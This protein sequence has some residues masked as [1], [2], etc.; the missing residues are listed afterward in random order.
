MRENQDPRIYP[1]AIRVPRQTP[2]AVQTTNLGA[3][4]WRDKETATVGSCCEVMVSSDSDGITSRLR[5][6]IQIL[7]E[8]EELSQRLRNH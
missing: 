6:G 5:V 8:P 3:N 4:P 1:L 7:P 2:R